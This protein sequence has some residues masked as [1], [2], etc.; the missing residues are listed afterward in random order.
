MEFDGS[1]LHVRPANIIEQGRLGTDH[2]VVPATEIASSD[3]KAPGLLSDGHL[4]VSTHSGK[5]HRL[6]FTRRQ[7]SD[8][9][10]L[11]RR[12]LDAIGPA[13]D[14]PP[15]DAA[16]PDDRPPSPTI[17][18][19]RPHREPVGTPWQLH[20]A[21]FF[22]QNVAGESYHDV[23]LRRI[24][25]PEPAGEKLMVAELRREPRNPHDRNAIRVLIDGN[26]V[27][28]IPREEAPAYQ[29]ELEAVESWGYPA[30]C[31]ARVW[32]RRDQWDFVASVSLDMAEPGRLVPLARAPEGQLLMPP[33]RWFQVS[34]EAEHMDVLLP[35]LGR[36]YFPGKAFAHARLELIDRPRPRSAGWAVQVLIDGDVV[37]ELSAQTSSRLRRLLGPLRDAQ[38][39]CYAEAELTGNSL[40]V[41]VRV[42]LTMPEELSQEF[43]KRVDAATSHRASGIPEP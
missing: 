35:L 40:A 27:G 25:G 14:A 20:T 3:I 6:C 11:H 9:Q 28:Y 41:E 33:G 42:S 2:L 37:G 17:P 39:P 23:E 16:S 1:C 30:Q 4:D 34:G 32:W 43:V 10:D 21:G 36:A 13:H 12:L 31:P 29:P 22:R 38:V 19:D 15:P 26:L 18:T 5:C 7:H 24:V 8:F